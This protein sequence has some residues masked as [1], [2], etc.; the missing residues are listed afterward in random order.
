MLTLSFNLWHAKFFAL[1]YF[2]KDVE[3]WFDVV[4]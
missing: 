2:A 1:S 3:V 4:I